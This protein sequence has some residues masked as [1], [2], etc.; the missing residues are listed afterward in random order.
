MLLS[1]SLSRK[2]VRLPV[3]PSVAGALLWLDLMSRRLK[4]TPDL[5]TVTGHGVTTRAPIGGWGW[6]GR[7]PQREPLSTKDNVHIYLKWSYRGS[8]DVTPTNFF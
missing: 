2:V 6:G 3:Y 1:Q 5:E 7:L 8:S 4:T